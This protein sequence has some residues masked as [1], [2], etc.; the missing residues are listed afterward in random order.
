[1]STPMNAPE[2][3]QEM[4]RPGLPYEQI[5]DI[6]RRARDAAGQV[7]DVY[8]DLDKFPVDP[9]RLAQEYGAEVFIGD[10][11]EDLDG[12][13]VPPRDGYGAQIYVDTDSSP[14]RQRFTTAHEL[15]HLVEDGERLQV[16]RRRDALSKE[17]TDPHE[18]FAN[19]FAAS[20][21]MPEFAVR[22][23]VAAG[24]A[25][26]RLHGFFGV[27]QLAMQHRLRN[28]RLND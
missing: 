23:L 12:F 25:R 17:G 5:Q 18:L 7:L 19:E 20:L 4:R 22:Q 15:G 11:K 8:W 10:L 26:A 28:L 9:V 27:S 6:K 14:A 3:Q 16:D 1:M 2:E 21:L 24:M 13:M